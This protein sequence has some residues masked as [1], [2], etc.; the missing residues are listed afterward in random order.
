MFSPTDVVSGCGPFGFPFLEAEFCPF[1]PL[2]DDW[3]HFLLDRGRPGFAGHF[4]FLASVVDAVEDCGSC[5][6]FVHRCYG[7]GQGRGVVDLFGVGDVVCPIGP[8]VI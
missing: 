7:R 3:V 1:S 8:A 2:S 6:V 4:Y 5:A